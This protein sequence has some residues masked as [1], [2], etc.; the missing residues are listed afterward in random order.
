MDATLVIIYCVHNARLALWFYQFMSD[1]SSV[2]YCTL[3][4]V[5]YWLGLLSF[6]YNVHSGTGLIL[7]LCL[8]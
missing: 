5:F 3:E 4:I 8:Y 6:Q 2:S 1:G 7:V